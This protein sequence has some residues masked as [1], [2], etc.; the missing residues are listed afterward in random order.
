MKTIKKFF[1]LLMALVIMLSSASV[2][3]FAEN[4]DDYDKSQLTAYVFNSEAHTI[5][6]NVTKD[7]VLDYYMTNPIYTTSYNQY[8]SSFEFKIV[9]S[10]NTEV[11]SDNGY[12]ETNTTL[13]YCVYLPK[14]NYT[15]TVK[16][17][18]YDS[19]YSY[20]YSYKYTLTQTTLYGK[21]NTVNNGAH[22]I[23]YRYLSKDNISYL[24]LTENSKVSLYATTPRDSE[25]D[26]YALY[27]KITNSVGTEVYNEYLS[28]SSIAPFRGDVYLTK[29]NYTINYQLSY[30]SDDDIYDCITNNFKTNVIPLSKVK[31]PT[32]KLTSESKSYGYGLYNLKFTWVDNNLYD[33]VELYTK[34]NS[35]KWK[36]TKTA[37][38][39]KY[40]RNYGFSTTYNSGSIVYYKVR[41]YKELNDKSKWYS[42]YSN[43]ITLKK[44]EKPTI[45][46]KPSKK[47]ATVKITKKVSNATGYEIYRSTKK[48]KGYKKVK[49][50]KS[51]SFKNKKLKSKKT[52]YYKVRAYKTVSGSKMY[53]AYTKPVKVKVK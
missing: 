38:N 27:V 39:S 52:Y 34:T 48:T 44:L 20:R 32:P 50:T 43:V 30:A 25:G 12:D 4:L 26:S 23:N 9:N 15:L 19:R 24:N 13:H 42:A 40:Y 17:R 5:T 45:S 49:T 21:S 36:L 14:G 53:S 22:Y 1:S 51:L 7:S 47:A 28:S 37:T 46:V 35:G 6:L 2:S 41:A 33:G 31:Y 29:G 3:V 16:D 10:N 11:Y 18:Y 8:N